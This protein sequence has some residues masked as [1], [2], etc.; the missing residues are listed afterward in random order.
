MNALEAR[1]REVL[2]RAVYDYYAGGAD[3][4]DTVAANRAAWGEIRFRPRVL[5]DVSSPDPSIELLGT[6]LPS[7][8][9]VAPTAFHR[10]AHADGERATARG[11][12]GRLMIA[13]SLSTVPIDEIVA[14]ASG[15]VWLQLYVFRERALSEGLVRRAEAAGCSG[16]CLTVDVPV[17]G[18]RERD[19]H[20]RFTLPDGI[21]IA[22]FAG[23]VQ[24][25]M[26][27]GEGSGLVRY[28]GTQFDPALD[29]SA[30]SW[31][32]GLT[33][34]PLILKG[35]QNPDD[36]RRAVEAGVDA[37]VVSNHGGRQLDGAEATARI[38]PDVVAA[39]EG[40]LPVLVDGGLRRGGDVAR[41]LAL[42]AR[43]VLLGRPV[44]WG[45]AT[46][47]AEGV[48]GVLDRFDEEF[49]RTLALLGARRPSELGPEALAPFRRPV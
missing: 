7:P 32:R 47:G 21:E 8:V 12:G 15:P 1:A 23:L 35:I 27:E 36:G 48:G 22:N 9:A 39:V 46:G 26:P 37:L 11:A 31:L 28:I 6:V 16:L 40:R 34:L 19:A 44:L 33:D 30:V 5:V 38:L 42:G 20:N 29:W 3:D 41:A 17:A 4:E 2:P 49:V 14:A 45:L 13:S 43:G 25:S 24:D 18:N 10:L